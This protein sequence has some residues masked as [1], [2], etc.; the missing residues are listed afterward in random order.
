MPKLQIKAILPVVFAIFCSSN[1]FSN[2]TLPW[3][4]FIAQLR[5]E[6]L[7]DNIRPEVFDEA[8]ANVHEP[9][10]RVLHLDKTQPEKRLTFKEYRNSRVDHYRIALGRKEFRRNQAALEKVS[11]RFGVDACFILSIWGLETSYGHYKG[12]FPVIQSLA[13]LT[14]DPRRSSF[15]HNELR[16]ALRMLNNNDVNLHDFKGE[17]AGAS[18][19]C[20]FLPSTYAKYAAS[21][22]GSGHADIWNNRNDAFASIANFLVKNGWH[23]NEPWAIEVSIPDDFSSSLI[24]NNVTKTVQEWQELGVQPTTDSLPDS[25][26]RASIINPDGGPAYMVF[27]N[28]KTLLKWNRSNYYVASLGYLAEEIC[29][30]NL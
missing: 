21:Y 7:A 16:M 10:H 24:S 2:N 1:A 14:Y 29:Q 25:H 9:S 5:E 11:Q 3:H 18:G 17:W 4:D 23:G 19:H 22:T 20:Q 30:H 13:T 15:F 6:A 26:L 8:F 28:F 12:N 27:D